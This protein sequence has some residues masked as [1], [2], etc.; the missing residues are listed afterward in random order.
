MR[1]PPSKACSSWGSA[2]T[3]INRLLTI[4]SIFL[5]LPALLAYEFLAAAP[6]V[7]L[8]AFGAE[9]EIGQCLLPAADIAHQSQWSLFE[10]HRI[11]NRSSRI[12][13]TQDLSYISLGHFFSWLDSQTYNF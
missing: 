11:I 1:S 6:E 13:Q 2:G 7:D 4:Y 9:S 3:I 10:L 12:I 8:Q 5:F